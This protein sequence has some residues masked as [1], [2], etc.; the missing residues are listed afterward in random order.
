MTECT[1]RELVKLLARK[2]EDKGAQA[3][4]AK[5][6]GVSPTLV[7]LTLSGKKPVGKT[8]AKALGYRKITAWVPLQTK[9]KGA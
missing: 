9:N 4:F 3:A 6:R 5:A 7:C 2:C 8:I 1:D